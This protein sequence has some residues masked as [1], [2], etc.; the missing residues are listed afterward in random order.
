MLV[1][2]V[3]LTDGKEV[4]LDAD[5][6][7][8]LRH[9][10]ILCENSQ[11]VWSVRCVNRLQHRK[12]SELAGQTCTM[13]GFSGY[14]SHNVLMVDENGDPKRKPP[15]PKEKADFRQFGRHSWDRLGS[16]PHRY[17][18][19]RSIDSPPAEGNANRF[20]ELV[21]APRH[22]CF[23]LYVECV[24]HSLIPIIV[25]DPNNIDETTTLPPVEITT[26][27]KPQ[28]TSTHTSVETTTKDPI[29]ITTEKPKPKPEEPKKPVKP[30]E[31]VI[32]ID[33]K[34]T[35]VVPFEPENDTITE[36][37]TNNFSAPW[38]ASI[39]ID[40]E[41]TCIGVLLGQN[42]VLVERSCVENVKYGGIFHA[43]K[44]HFQSAFPSLL[45]SYCSTNFI[46]L[47][48]QP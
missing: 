9:K 32:Q 1:I 38:T 34:P 43:I 21:G 23:A 7:P 4:L 39:F 29:E 35:I 24:P 6:R 26:Q 42:W 27:K 2:S 17:L 12:N 19:K 5:L 36:V 31:P 45:N 18:F 15:A 33:D 11:G 16:P 14:S 3:A 8:N 40:G 47:Q 41:L 28:E 48:S 10:G 13:L 46:F 25:P 37:I 44:L 22:Q 20:T 30:I